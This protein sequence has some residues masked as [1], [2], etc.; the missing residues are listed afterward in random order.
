MEESSNIVNSTDK[1][2]AIIGA[3]KATLA[4]TMSVAQAS[5]L[6]DGPTNPDQRP[7]PSPEPRHTMA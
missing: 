7:V 3:N 6:P 4:Q 1:S 5:K 2:Q